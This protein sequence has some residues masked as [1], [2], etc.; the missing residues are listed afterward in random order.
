M[1][2]TGELTGVLFPGQAFH[3]HSQLYTVAYSSL[4]RVVVSWGFLHFIGFLEYQLPSLFPT[5]YYQS[6]PEPGEC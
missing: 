4:C 3:S 1:I 2:G 5:Q 6:T